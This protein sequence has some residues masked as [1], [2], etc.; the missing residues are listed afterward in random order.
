MIINNC[1]DKVFKKQ[2][3]GK[4]PGEPLIRFVAK[5]Y[6]HKKR[7]CLKFLELGCGPE[8]NLWYLAN[9]GI[10][11]SA[12]EFSSVAVKKA[13][14]RLDAEHPGWRNHSKII[15]CDICTHDFGYNQFD[16][17]IDN[18]CVSCCSY[19]DA[20]VIYEKAYQALKK[21]GKIFI[22]TFTTKHYG[23]KTGAKL[24]Y[25][26]Y[27]CA[28]GGLKGKGSVRFT[29]S[30][31]LKKLLYKY[32]ILSQ[33]EQTTKHMNKKKILSEWIVIAKK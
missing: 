27:L 26:Y 17:I 32:K 19:K 16:A 33:A 11:F 14:S 10:P 21:N 29:S 18:E 12:L 5:N 8:G 9:E 1:W 22:R 6:Y 13:E 3:W 23:Y 4:Y 25:K 24:G 30:H 7:S 31:D 28:A 2:E 15:N 20:L